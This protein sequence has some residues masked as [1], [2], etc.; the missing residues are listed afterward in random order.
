MEIPELGHPQDKEVRTARCGR[1]EAMGAVEV[2]QNEEE[3]A[4]GR[5]EEAEDSVQPTDST[6]TLRS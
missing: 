6:R 4:F 5:P 2:G 1:R 3:M